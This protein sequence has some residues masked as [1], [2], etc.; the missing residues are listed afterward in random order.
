MQPLTINW[1]CSPGK[2]TGVF[3]KKNKKKEKEKVKSKS[4]TSKT[5]TF[6]HSSGIMQLDT[7]EFSFSLDLYYV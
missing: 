5:C 3:F 2:I 7:G 6:W 1:N 4:K